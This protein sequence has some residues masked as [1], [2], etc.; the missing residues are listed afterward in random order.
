LFAVKGFDATS[1]QDVVEAVGLTKGAFYYYFD[2]KDQLLYEMHRRVISH[3]LSSAGEILAATDDPREA[4]RALVI[5]LIDSI[6]RYHDEVTIV[7]REHHR[8][9]AHDLPKVE[10]DRLRYQ[11]LLTSVIT[12]GQRRGAI[13][14]DISAELLTR[15]L[16]G[17]C[18]GAKDWYLG[19]DWTE[20]GDVGPSMALIFLEGIVL[21]AGDTGTPRST[22]EDPQPGQVGV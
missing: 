7:L 3:Q 19:S 20:T 11:D 1:V 16:L 4:L 17:I 13:R 9:P 6:D 5:D 2:S 8:F 10:A 21:R 14:S 22:A 18:T 15:A 12:E